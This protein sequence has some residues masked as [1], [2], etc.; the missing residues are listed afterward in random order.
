MA[1][2]VQSDAHLPAMVEPRVIGIACEPKQGARA[3][4]RFRLDKAR[5]V[6]SCSRMKRE[7][8]KSQEG[9]EIH[10]GPSSML[11]CRLSSTGSHRRA[12]QPRGECVS[13]LSERTDMSDE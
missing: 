1:A 8:A 9:G 6:R 4:H 12:V 13:P 3:L 2:D 11:F 5:K 7:R 10:V